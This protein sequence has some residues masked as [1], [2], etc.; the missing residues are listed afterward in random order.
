MSVDAQQSQI[1]RRFATAQDA[2]DHLARGGDEPDT[3]GAQAKKFSRLRRAELSVD[4][5]FVSGLSGSFWTV[6]HVATGLV[7]DRGSSKNRMTEEQARCR[8]N[9][10]DAATLD[11]ERIDWQTPGFSARLK[12]DKRIESALGS[13]RSEGDREYRRLQ[14]LKLDDEL[15]SA[16]N[17]QA[18]SGSR[19]ADTL[20]LR[21]HYAQGGDD[22]LP[23]EN[24]RLLRAF[25]RRVDL[26]ITPDG[27]FAFYETPTKER[28]TVVPLGIGQALDNF[29][30]I[31]DST[32]DHK[33][34][35]GLA[36]YFADTIYDADGRGLAW[37][38][39]EFLKQIPTWRSERGENFAEAVMRARA[40]YDRALGLN[41]SE[42]LRIFTRFG[43]QPERK[44]AAVGES[45]ADD[46]AI[47][48][49]IGTSED[50]MR[51]VEAISEKS[52]SFTFTL[53]GG[54]KLK[55]ERNSTLLCDSVVERVHVE[56]ITLM[57]FAT[58][59]RSNGRR[60]EEAI[61]MI[62]FARDGVL[63]DLTQRHY[64][65]EPD[66][67]ITDLAKTTV[68]LGVVNRDKSTQRWAIQAE[69]A[70]NMRDY[71]LT[72]WRAYL[73]KQIADGKYVMLGREDFQSIIGTSDAR[74]RANG[75][76]YNV[77]SASDETVG[78][79]I[80]DAP[81]LVRQ[82]KYLEIE[83]FMRDGRVLGRDGTVQS[84]KAPAIER[85]VTPLAVDRAEPKA[86]ESTATDHNGVPA[87][88]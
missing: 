73:R 17:Q 39:S 6:L 1:A 80:A 63:H 71:E 83:L 15:A 86:V 47:G 36:Q 70:L 26:S 76:W 2:L 10:Y 19:F 46:I 28:F 25:S 85:V 49:R 45:Y 41:D 77:V 69:T 9:A 57:D 55:L 81:G 31:S 21:A 64:A 67:T 22:D 68:G 35:H 11:G 65:R 7:V 52:G 37:D 82:L 32:R 33:V 72:F 38:S 50:T 79:A 59:A 42:A 48:D 88:F 62:T 5:A 51:R 54:R 8:A 44:P 13:A 34:V 53:E 24:K 66:G 3:L 58:M 84:Q 16:P 60:A 75:T 20:A 40:G 74:I 14:E 61:A 87:L 78:C 43:R 27:Q 23:E 18:R 30:T 29:G 4:G 12:A 56:P